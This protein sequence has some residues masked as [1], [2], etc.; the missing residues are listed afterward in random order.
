MHPIVA[1][2]YQQ[3]QPDPITRQGLELLATIAPDATPVVP[4]RVGP[5]NRPGESILQRLAN[6]AALA[7]NDEDAETFLMREPQLQMS[8]Q[9]TT[10]I[11]IFTADWCGPCKQLKPALHGLA[12]MYP[13]VRFLTVDLTSEN[14]GNSLAKTQ[15]KF[16]VQSLPT[17]VLLQHGY[18]KGR[19]TIPNIYH[20]QALVERGLKLKFH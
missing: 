4:S 2:M 8:A 5:S 15:A 12:S 10:L 6:Y 11:L 1:E 18:E 19:C 16:N 13:G 3:T 9:N 17:F 14:N 20:V 7:D